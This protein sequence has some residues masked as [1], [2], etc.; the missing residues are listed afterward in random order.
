MTKLAFYWRQLLHRM[1]FLPA[2][3]SAIAMLTIGIALFVARWAPEELPFTISRDAIQSI[4]EILATSLLTVSV[5][6]LSTL[7]AALSSASAATSPRAMPLII[8]DRAAQ[9]SISVFIGAFLF[10]ILAILGLSAGIYSS[11]GRMLLFSVTLAVVAVVIAALIRWIAQIS[12]IGRVG[13]TVDRV[14]AATAQA[15]ET[16]RKHPQFDCRTQHTP[17]QGTPVHAD[18][19][20]YVQH[21]DAARLQALAEEHD[22]RIAITARPGTYVS[23]LRPLML[24]ETN[25]ERTL[26]DD[27][28]DEL[29]D[30]FVIGDQRSFDSDPRFGLVVLAEIADRALSPAVND[31]GTAIDVI[32]TLTRILADW[33]PGASADAASD[34]SVANDRLTIPAL[35]PQDLCEDAFRPIARDGAGSIEV[36]LRLIKSLEIL[37]A[38]NPHLRPAALATASDA[39]E[40]ARKALTAAEDLRALEEAARFV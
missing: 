8:G 36:L 5:F 3:F 33:Q 13:H 9:T 23:A 14:E 6:A 31:P 4:L 29:V 7:V 20:G 35:L 11:A 39:V 40:P 10:S 19:L 18:K 34:E 27:T 15:F 16:L 24:V 12:D 17:P 38:S 1:W 28:A 25:S 32:G 30:T 2:A 22:L 21:F 37:A 26:D